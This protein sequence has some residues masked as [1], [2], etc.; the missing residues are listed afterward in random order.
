MTGPRQPVEGFDPAAFRSDKLPT[1]H[2]DARF[3]DENVWHWVPLL[4]WAGE[5]GPSSR[6]L[7]VG[8]GTGG[9]ARA[10]A[11]SVGAAV[12]G[13]DASLRFIDHARS[14]PKPARGSVEWVV[15]DAEQLPV[16][17]G[18]FDCV[19]LSLVLH[20]VSRP[21]AALREARR[22]LR[23]GGRVVIRTIAP[24]DA[25]E[26]VPARF[27]PSMAAADVARMPPIDEIEALL[28][29]AGLV[30][31]S[32]F[33]SLRNATL[34]FD[35]EAEAARTEI[36]SRYPFIGRGEL[37]SGLRSMASAAAEATTWI[38]PRPTYFIVALPSTNA[39][40]ANP[41]RPDAAAR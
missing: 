32:T 29:R 18:A 27:F 2:F 13:C 1:E 39:G 21:D 38:D 11:A 10:I 31:T 30:V 5:I 26:R 19:V 23:D 36:A 25:A 3:S 15:G 33:R 41:A 7:D 17:G 8:C 20:Q 28:A 40:R 14:T 22:A 35:R 24:E 4:V 12:T 37:E 6:V 16:L 9:F 34:D